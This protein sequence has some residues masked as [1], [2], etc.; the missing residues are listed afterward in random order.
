MNGFHPE[1]ARMLAGQ[2]A[3][4]LHRAASRRRSRRVAPRTRHF[5]AT[6]FVR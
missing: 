3:A 1:T 5:L 6:I 4:D 2:H